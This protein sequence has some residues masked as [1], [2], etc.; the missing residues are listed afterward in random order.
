MNANKVVL[1]GETLID[2]T[3]DTVKEEYV[4]KGITFHKADGSEAV[5]TYEL[6]AERVITEN[7]IYDVTEYATANVNVLPL[8]Q[9]KT[10][11]PTKSVQTVTPDI[12][13]HALSSVVIEPIPEEYIIPSGT[14]DINK[15]GTHD[16]KDYANVNINVA[17]PPE[18]S[19]ESEMNALLSSAS[20]SSVGAVYKY[21]GATTSTYTNGELYI[22]AKE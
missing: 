9:G 5:G 17:D 2:L 12:P 6:T 18:I 8:M 13:Y 7:G 15:N 3:A 19:T 1:N 11:I 21:V 14:K 16:V 4:K 22:I 20:E 10:V